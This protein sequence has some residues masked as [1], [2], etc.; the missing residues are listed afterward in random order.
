M[1][2]R[3]NSSEIASSKEYQSFRS[4][5]SQK[6]I[7]VDCEGKEHTWIMYDYGPRDVR[8]P[9][10]FF[11]PVSGTADIFFKQIMSLGAQG[12]RCISVDYPVV[13]NHDEFCRSFAKFLDHIRLDQVH[14]FGASLGAF[15]AQKFAEH[16][17][18]CQ[19]VQS[20]IICNGFTDTAIFTDMPPAMMMKYMPNFVLR[21]LILQSYPTQFLDPELANAVEF[22][23]ERLDHIT[24]TELAS[25]LTLNVLAAYIEPQKLSQQNIHITLIDVLD[26]CA[27]TPEVKDELAK[28][29]PDAKVA[30]M[31]D[32][33]NFPY[34][35]RAEE[36]N[37]FIKV[38]V[39]PFNK[40]RYSAL[41][42]F[43]NSPVPPPP[44]AAAAES[45]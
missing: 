18:H 21:K 30:H 19:R 17:Y 22:M 39:R 34:L 42:D 1:S 14:I 27:V 26:K 41:D 15:L 31:K 44:G 5:I 10:V 13:W 37:L 8:C 32:G 28:C 23:L 43:D 29:Y 36:V 38:H 45:S 11:P 9:L 6:R 35:S 25:R 3:T 16:T 33:G 40:T 20:L 7:V 12:Y 4:S 2:E 24:R